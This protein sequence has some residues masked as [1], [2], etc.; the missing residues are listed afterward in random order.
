MTH[1]VSA[2]VKWALGILLGVVLAVVGATTAYAAHYAD[3]ALPGV[4][5]AGTSVTGQTQDEVAGAV[6]KRADDLTVT[7]NIDGTPTSAKL[8][9]LGITVDAKAT[10]A[11]A[12]ADNSSWTSR[13]KALF[14]P[15]DVAVVSSTDDAAL[16]TY[17][18][19]LAASLGDPATDATVKASGDG[20]SF[21]TT[22]AVS[23]KGVD[24]QALTT[25]AAKAVSSLTSQSVDLKSVDATPKVTTEAA[26]K[27]AD[28]ANALVALDVTIS[29]GVTSHT[30]TAAEKVGWVDIPTSDSGLGT[31]AFK[32]SSVT[33]WV[34]KT[35][36]STNEDPVAGIKNVNS[37]GAVV[38]VASAG[39]NGWKVNNADAVA[40]AVVDSL[41]K[42]TSYSGSFDYDKIE[43]TYTTRVIADGAEKLVYQAAAGEKWVDVNL[44][45][46][47]VTA[48]EGATVV[49]GPVYMVPGAP[50][51]PTATGTF[52]VYL[53]YASQTMRGT[54]VDGTSYETPDVPWVTYF[55]GSYALHGAP[56]RSSFGWGGEGGSHGC[57]NMPVDGAK[58]FYDWTEIG[59]TVVSHK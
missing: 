9:A 40:K 46:Y 38:A 22:D 4:S 5:V 43:P 33:D 32:D 19:N 31:P 35:A 42:D 3:R 47:T 8:T 54:N 25:A 28:A 41:T 21:V 13:V 50:A 58:W 12:F 57:V 56:W 49:H 29:D 26:R 18:K 2:K 36:E 6:A 34:R 52:H 1:N 44:S 15:Q 53:K 20:T 23:G 27:A 55:T 51:T 10:A 59:T 30:A 11:K 14:S 45:T 16:A 17:G 7:V 39:K 37:K 48:Y 24:T